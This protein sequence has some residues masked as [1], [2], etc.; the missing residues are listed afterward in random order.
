MSIFDTTT[1]ESTPDA[2]ASEAPDPGAGVADPAASADLP[3]ADGGDGAPEAPAAPQYL[4]VEQYGD[5]LVKAK[6]DG[7]ER[8]LPFKDAVNGIMMQQAFTKRTQELAEERRRLQQAA[9]LADALDQNPADTLKQLSEVY[10][11][12]PSVGFERVQREPEE[13]RLLDM[14]R[15][16][17]VQQEQLVRQRLDNEIA[18]L[19]AQHGDFDVMKVARYAHENGM[20]LTAAHKLMQFEELQ[21]KQAAEAENAKRQ[22]AAREA[23]GTVHS[24]AATQR[25]TVGQQTRPAT[26]IREA[27]LMAKRAHGA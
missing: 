24:G 9:M 11:L 19:R 16:L 17:A 26:S 8:E 21:Q 7:E 27:F 2:G 3:P 13:Q 4:D 20:N 18:G 25:G 15:N 10:D 14:Q 5:Y 1:P 23:A 22:A 6:V 12:D